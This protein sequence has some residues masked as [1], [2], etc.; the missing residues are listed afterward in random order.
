MLN[1]G[2]GLMLTGMG[3]VFSFLVV[4]WIAV[5]LM[6]QVVRKLN[7]IFPEQVATVQKTVAKIS[8]DVE[9]AISIAAAKM[10]R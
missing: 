2:I 3:T 1:E 5:S 4:L 9:V 8:S 10:K 7:E 6:G